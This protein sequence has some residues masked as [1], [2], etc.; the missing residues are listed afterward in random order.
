MK[1]YKFRAWCKEEK[2]MCSVRGIDF[3]N[4]WVMITTPEGDNYTCDI[5][6]YILMQYTDLKDKNDK[7]IFDGDFLKFSNKIFYVS[8]L[9]GT[10]ALFEDCSMNVF[11]SY[12]C[13]MCIGH[14]GIIIGNKF[15]NPELLEEI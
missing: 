1:E 4:E 14:G 2:D 6:D 9:G 10:P 12:M 3:E 13:N 7:K 11:C 15:D 5:K 8:Y